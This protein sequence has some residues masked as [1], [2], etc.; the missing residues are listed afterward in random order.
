[1]YNRT[2]AHVVEVLTERIHTSKDFILRLKSEKNLANW[3]WKKRVEGQC[4][5]EFHPAESVHHLSSVVFVSF[6]QWRLLHYLYHYTKSAP[7]IHMHKKLKKESWRQ[8][9]VTQVSGIGNHHTNNDHIVHDP[10]AC[11][12]GTLFLCFLRWA[13]SGALPVASLTFHLHYM[14]ID[15]CQKQCLSCRLDT[16]NAFYGE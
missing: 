10:L 14:D 13:K 1:M 5:S 2:A 8:K 11:K 12:T 7:C 6:T 16:S 15:D 4:L 9:V 3:F